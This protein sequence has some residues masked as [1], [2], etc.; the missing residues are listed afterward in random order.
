MTDIEKKKGGRKR[1]KEGEK[2]LKNY[3]SKRGL[4]PTI[5]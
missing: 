1:G 5:Q 2:E 3:E 4:I